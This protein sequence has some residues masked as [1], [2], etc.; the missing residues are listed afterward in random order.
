M[1]EI[2]IKEGRISK[3][4]I[5]ILI[6]RDIIAMCFLLGFFWIIRDVI[7]FDTTRLKITNKRITGKRGLINTN[8]LDSPLNKISGVQVEQGLLGHLFNYGT[9]KV[10][11][12]STS[13]KY[14]YIDKPNE[15]REA[16][17]NQIEAYDEARIEQQ[18]KKIAEAVKS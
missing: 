14:D 4:T 17:N 6:I 13:F 10:T 3:I 9:I 7:T 16:L 2:L 12:A 11:T 1:E 18:A 15:F 8:Q 5:I